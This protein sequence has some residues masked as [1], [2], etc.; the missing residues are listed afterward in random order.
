MFSK[1]HE[2]PATAENTFSDSRRVRGRYHPRI[3]RYDGTRSCL[4]YRRSYVSTYLTSDRRTLVQFQKTPSRPSNPRESKRISE[5]GYKIKDGRIQG[6]LA[7]AR[8]FGDFQFKRD[9]EKD[10]LEQAVSCLPDVNHFTRSDQVRPFRVS[11][12]SFLNLISG[13][14]HF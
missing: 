7:V 6:N 8:A 11:F 14:N 2:S 9:K 4:Q 10:Q 5:C 13:K 3:S 12:E 1:Y